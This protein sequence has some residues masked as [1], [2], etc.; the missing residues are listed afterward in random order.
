MRFIDW[1]RPAG[2][3]LALVFSADA[4]AQASAADIIEEARARARQVEELK[5][6]LNDPDQNVRLAAFEAMVASDDPLM[7]ELAL[8]AGLASTDQVL[9]GMAL[10]HAVLSLKQLNITLSAD[11]SAPK[12][13]QELSTAYLTKSGNNYV[14]VMDPKTSDVTRGT[15]NAPG[16]TSHT[17]NVSGLVVTFNY[18]YYTGELHLQDDNTLGGVINHSRSGAH[19]FKATAPLR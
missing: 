3:A 5:Q 17:G 7:R 4:L 2:L 6:I 13:V 16:N 15:F 10:R 14:L 19:R 9:R 11:E 8:D 1:I 18:Q 12:P